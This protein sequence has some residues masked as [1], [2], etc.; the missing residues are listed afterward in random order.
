MEF[1]IDIP[2]EV[3]QKAIDKKL[4]EMG[5]VPTSKKEAP[6]D[7]AGPI[8]KSLIE[9]ARRLGKGDGKPTGIRFKMADGE[10]VETS[11]GQTRKD[12]AVA[13][14]DEYGISVARFCNAALELVVA[15]H[16]AVKKSKKKGA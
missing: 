7:G 8:M 5:G 12:E 9:T 4:A 3:I 11:V 15:E 10:L 1:K 6:I 14:L 2:D 13:I 16:Q